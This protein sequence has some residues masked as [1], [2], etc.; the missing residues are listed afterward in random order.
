[1]TP[2]I[3]TRDGKTELVVGTPG[4][5]TI[6]NSVL[7]VL[8]N[9]VDFGMNVQDAVDGRAFIINGCPISYSWSA[10]FRPT[11]SHC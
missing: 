8:V 3:V 10:A 11:P 9:V 2:T 4:G 6:I 5:P 1:M 7:E